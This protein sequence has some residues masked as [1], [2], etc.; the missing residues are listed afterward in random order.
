MGE[1]DEMYPDEAKKEEKKPKK[2]K[3]LTSKDFFE[4]K[5]EVKATPVPKPRLN[6][7]TK[8]LN[9]IGEVEGLINAISTGSYKKALRGIQELRE[10]VESLL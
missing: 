7:K 1:Y 8:I 3:V 10:L 9:K 4:P 5:P 6:K 2:E